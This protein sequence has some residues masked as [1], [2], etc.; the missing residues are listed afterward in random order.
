MI[1]WPGLRTKRTLTSFPDDLIPEWGT[2]DEFGHQPDRTGTSALELIQA[3]PRY[4]GRAVGGAAGG[5]R[6]RRS[7]LHRDPARCRHPDR[8][9]TWS[10]RWLPGR[11]RITAAAAAVQCDRGPRPGD[12]G[13]GRAPQHQRSR[14]P[15]RLGA[16]Q[17]HPGPPRA[18]R[19][20]G[21][22]RSTNGGRRPRPERG[23]TGS[24]HRDQRW[25]RP[26]RRPG[27]CASTTAASPARSG[28]ARSTP[29]PSWCGTAAGT[30]CA[31]RTRPAA[32]ARTASTA[33]SWPTCSTSRWS[34]Q[35]DLDD[36]VASAGG[37][38]RGGLGVLGGRRLR[39]RL[40]RGRGARS[41]RRSAG[42]EPVDDHRVR[43]SGTTSNPHW[44][45]QQL[46]YVPFAFEICSGEEIRRAARELGRQLLASAGG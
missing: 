17:D 5:V 6:A 29:G 25:S 43:L 26:A 38:P 24:G 27:G 18:G 13:A 41:R 19:R 37:A 36:P 34:S 20:T 40:R 33:S 9:R 1:G 45:A 11:S 31:G 44:Y 39:G 8:V 2:P 42:C 22:G 23:S 15:G 7:P 46:T 28:P 12:G 4:H 30:C 21:R 16:G 10:V 3:R 32:D 35:A 14:R